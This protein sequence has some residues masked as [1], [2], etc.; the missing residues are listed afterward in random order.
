MEDAMPEPTPEPKEPMAKT[1][2]NGKASALN[3]SEGT[4]AGSDQ[5][6]WGV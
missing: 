5:Y 1:V 4:E 3:P 6:G 2:P